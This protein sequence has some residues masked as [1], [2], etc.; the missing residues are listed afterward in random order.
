MAT[1]ICCFRYTTFAIAERG[2]SHSPAVHHPD[3]NPFALRKFAESRADE[4]FPPY[5]LPGT[6]L[7]EDMCA[8]VIQRWDLQNQVVKSEIIRLEPL[9]Q[10]F[11]LWLQDGSSMMARRVV[12]AIGGGKIQI[13]DWVSQ[14]TAKYPLDKLCHSHKVDYCPRDR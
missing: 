10:G 3:P 4:L 6:Q 9:S 14:I 7:F 11:R 13:P 8:D 1:T 5:D 12:L 2:V